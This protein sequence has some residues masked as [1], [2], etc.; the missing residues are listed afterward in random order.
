MLQSGRHFLVVSAGS[1]GP[2]ILQRSR[3]AC[4]GKSLARYGARGTL[5]VSKGPPLL[6]RGIPS[7]TGARP[8]A[9]PSIC[10]Y[11]SEERIDCS[12]RRTVDRDWPSSAAISRTLAP[13]A[14]PRWGS[15]AGMLV[16]VTS[17]WFA[18]RTWTAGDRTCAAATRCCA[19]GWREGGALLL[20]RKSWTWNGYGT[21]VAPWSLHSSRRL[22]SSNCALIRGGG[23]GVGQRSR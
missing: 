23:F 15:C 4:F 8:G 12:A 18:S 17:T 5:A 21:A 11:R 6:L 22:P 7:P 1:S 2:P 16:P 9:R 13:P 14:A 10:I 20:Y 3:S 19:S